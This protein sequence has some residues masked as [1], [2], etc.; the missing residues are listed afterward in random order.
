VLIEQAVTADQASHEHYA[1]LYDRVAVAAKR[2]QRYGTQ[3]DDAGEP[4]AIE[5]AVNVDARRKEVGL[6]T[7]AEYR[8]QM[9]ELYGPKQ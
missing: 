4:Y 8:S 3:F 1:Y 2:P 7:M 5:D 6:G 9:R